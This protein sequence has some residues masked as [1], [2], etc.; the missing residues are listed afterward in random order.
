MS[1]L[2]LKCY[3]QSSTK[4]IVDIKMLLFDFKLPVSPVL[5]FRALMAFVFAFYLMSFHLPAARRYTRRFLFCVNIQQNVKKYKNERQRYVHYKSQKPVLKPGPS[6]QQSSWEL[7]EGAIPILC[8]V[9]NWQTFSS[10]DFYVTPMRIA[11]VWPRIVA[12]AM[13]SLLGQSITSYLTA[14]ERR[15]MV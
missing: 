9:P 10:R 8:A 7:W 3:L 14:T 6:T 5:K 12:I 13:T 2:C 11:T 4:S 1:F 15:T